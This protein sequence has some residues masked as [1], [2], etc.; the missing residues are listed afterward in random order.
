MP[1]SWIPALIL[2]LFALSLTAQPDLVVIG[3]GVAGMA[4]ALEAANNGANVVI[5]EMSSVFGGHALMSEGGLTL[6]DT[7]TQRKLGVRDSAAIAREDI[8]RWGETPNLPWVDR[9][10]RDSAPEVHDWL[11][12]LGLKFTVLRRPA[13][14]TVP[15]FHENAERGLGVAKV[16]FRACVQSPRVRFLWH[17][18]AVELLKEGGRVSGVLVENQRTRKRQLVKASSVA[19]ATGG[20]Q[21]NLDLLRKH[22]AKDLGF[23]ERLLVGSGVNSTGSGHEMAQ[24][25]GAALVDM[26]RQWNYPWG[27][28]DPRYTEGVRGISVRM[29]MGIWVNLEGKRFVDEHAS[30]KDATPAVLAQPGARYWIVVDADGLQSFVVAGT[31][32]TDARRVRSVLLNNPNIVRSGQTLADLA[33]RTGLPADTLARTVARYNHLVASGVDDDFGRFGKG[34]QLYQASHRRAPAPIGKAPFYAMQLFALSRKSMGGIATD[35]EARVLDATGNV[36]P[37]LYAVGEASG[38]GGLNGTAALEGTFLAPGILQGRIVGRQMRGASPAT[39]VQ[40]RT[41]LSGTT[42]AGVAAPCQT[43]HDVAKL[44][45]QK[46][47]GYWHFDRVHARV[48]ERK[49]SCEQCHAGMTPFRM[50]THKID[51][52]AQAEQCAVCHLASE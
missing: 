16:L 2:P 17:T 51:R 4:T 14:N 6:V 41:A 39:H 1:R 44:V 22:W 19:L 21:S 50:A 31:D 29:P 26:E 40:E 8:V 23:P 30:P 11:V 49:L 42:E 47:T 20:F 24:R 48:L 37:G 7:A 45:S 28:P 13:G 46:R 9:Y 10:V 33:E 38:Q 52:I 36:I 27:L 35:N 25:A 43:C 32:W 34:R 15:R 3:A 12:S 18:K 5:V